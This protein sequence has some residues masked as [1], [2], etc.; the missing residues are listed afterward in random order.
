MSHVHP[1]DMH[2]TPAADRARSL[3]RSLCTV[4]L[5]LGVM[6]GVSGCQ[7]D[8]PLNDL[9][10][11]HGGSPSRYLP[12]DGI[13]V[14]W[15]DEG[16]VTLPAASLPVLLLHGTGAS[17]HTWDGWARELSREFRVVR[18]DLPGFG[19]TG[20]H[21]SGDYSPAAMV[22]FLERFA[23][24]AGLQQFVVAGNSLGGL[25]AW[26]FALRRPD[27]VRA[28]ILVDAAGYPSDLSGPGTLGLRLARM[29]VV[30]ELMRWAPVEGLVG[31]GLRGAY[32]DPRRVSPEL[33]DRYARLLR[34]PG[35]RIAMGDR[36][37]GQDGSRFRTSACRLW[38]YGG[39]VIPGCHPRWV[40]ASNG[41]SQA[42]DWSSTPTWDM[43]PW[44]K[45]RP[46]P[47]AMQRD[48]CASWPPNQAAK[49]Y[50]KRRLTEHSAAT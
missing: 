17:L 5:T 8:L 6:M 14:H 45:I 37:R 44:K 12:M 2:P 7:T 31:S 42:V 15:R 40:S 35:N 16:P 46:L 27:R 22:D 30:S 19:L 39:G 49:G 33:V 29:P 24:A 3:L 38:C 47:W 34:R 36:P 41:I 10:A 25:Y 50:D 13:E 18:L 1:C 20:P 32:A 43:Y 9:K 11:R 26:R 28:L 4:V 48:S 23:D 21:P